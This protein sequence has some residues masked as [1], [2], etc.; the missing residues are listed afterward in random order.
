[1]TTYEYLMER[2]GVTMT[3]ADV[4]EVLS[5]RF[6]DIFV[7]S[8]LRLVLFLLDI[9]DGTGKETRVRAQV[10]DLQN[11]LG[12]EI[13]RRGDTGVGLPFHRVHER[14][15][16]AGIDRTRKAEVELLGSRRRDE[17]G[18]LDGIGRLGD[19]VGD[20]LGGGEALAAGGPAGSARR[21]AL[22]SLGNPGGCF[23][24]FGGSLYGSLG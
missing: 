23:S 17:N 22:L 5:V 10:V 2:Y 19:L 9:D 8:F 18:L 13:V 16:V 6:D 11:F 4:A 20:Y 21:L 14:H 15:A 3:T 12:E 24:L 7:K 1:M